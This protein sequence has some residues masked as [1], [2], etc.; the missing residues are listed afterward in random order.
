M[1]HF[2]VWNLEDDKG[3]YAHYLGKCIHVTPYHL[4]EYLIAEAKAETG[5]TKIF[6]YTDYK[7]FAMFPSVVKKINDI[8]YLSSNM[9]ADLYDMITPHEYS[10]ILSNVD[11]ISIQKKLLESIKKY[12]VDS[13]IIFSFVRINP[14]FQKQPQV[15]KECGFD[16]ILSNNQVYVDLKQ[17]SEAIYGAYKSN[18]KRNVKRAQREQLIFEIAKKNDKNIGIF[19]NL[20]VRA[21]DILSARRFLYFNDEYYKKLVMCECTKLGFVKEHEG[22]VIAAGIML[23]QGNVA[24]YHLGCFDRDY[25]IKRPMNYLIHSM[26]MWAKTQGYETFHIGGGGKSLM[27]FK[28]GYSHDRIKYYIAYSILDSRKYEIIRQKWKNKYPEYGEIEYY[29]IY[30]Y[31]E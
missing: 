19:Q 26:I 1:A 13:G 21:M 31:N 24:Y 20:Y 3:K 12:C 17:T 14:Y 11:L 2:E 6:L 23:T 10:G 18:V 27:Q 28:E 8:E 9:E 4:T 7:D 5:V 22:K 15:F 25:S 30:R 29:P 16:L